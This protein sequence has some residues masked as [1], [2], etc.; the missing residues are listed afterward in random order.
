[1]RKEKT[2]LPRS[3]T[4]QGCPNS[5]FL[6]NTVPKVLAKAIRIIRKAMSIANEDIK[7]SLFTDDMILSVEKTEE[8]PK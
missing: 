4:K 8:S 6:Y 3:G 2:F 7:L 1:V 5:H